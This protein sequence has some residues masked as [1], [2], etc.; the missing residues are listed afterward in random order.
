MEKELSPD[1]KGFKEY[2]GC[3]KKLLAIAKNKN[4]DF[5][6]VE[7]DEVISRLFEMVAILA[8]DEKNISGDF[9]SN[10]LL[11]LTLETLTEFLDM[12]LSELHQILK[13]KE[14]LLQPI[15]SAKKTADYQ[16]ILTEIEE[17]L[18]SRISREKNW[19]LLNFVQYGKALVKA[20]GDR[21]LK[22]KSLPIVDA[23][24]QERKIME[25][26]LKVY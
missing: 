3:V 20:L 12:G 22:G 9:F 24:S 19:R 16:K 5:R 4:N 18:K 23:L 1:K 8:K 25:R 26:R 13:T 17:K 11:T 15:I 2:L 21:D 6:I 7:Y 14:E 10:N